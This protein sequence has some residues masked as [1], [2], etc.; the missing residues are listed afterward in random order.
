MSRR[1]LSSA[2]LASV[3]L[4]GAS[5][6]SLGA[7]AEAAD[8]TPAFW[9]TRL[10]NLPTGTPIGGGLFQL[11]ISH[12]F[13][14]PVELGFKD[15]FGLDG[16]ANTLLGLGYGITDRIGLSLSRARLDKEIELG[17]EWLIAEQDAGRPFSAALFGGVGLVTEGDGLAR[18]SAALSLSRKVGRRLSILAVPAFASRTDR[19]SPGSG[20]TFTLGL[21]GR[22]MLL[23]DFS[24]L[25]EWTPVLAGFKADE[26]GWGLGLE[27]KTAGHVFQVFLANSLGL[28]IPQVLP[29][30]DLRLGDLDFRIGF[31]IFRAF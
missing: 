8:T 3:L 16:Y 26:S 6:C 13:A 25:A 23:E 20:G 15:F 11:R 12:R 5:I 17:A 10:F 31:N 9:G 19:N 28:T 4:L 7:A 2:A 22:F 14:A 29:G 1:M 24:I 21:G 18:W 27:L 30:G